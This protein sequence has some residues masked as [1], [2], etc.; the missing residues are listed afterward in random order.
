LTVLWGNKREFNEQQFLEQLK[1]HLGGGKK[2][3][4]RQGG[5]SQ[6]K[7]N[8]AKGYTTTNPG[9]ILGVRGGRDK[10]REGRIKSSDDKG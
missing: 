3:V 5:G 6:A 10:R 2:V 9:L 7:K 4:R 1:G 8:S